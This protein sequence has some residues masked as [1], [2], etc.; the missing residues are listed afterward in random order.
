MGATGA[1]GATGVADATVIVASSGTVQDGTLS[2]DLVYTSA[3]LL[4]PVGT[5]L[6]FG[7][8][9]VQTTNNPDEVM[10][11]IWDSTHSTD[12]PNSNSAVVVTP[13]VGSPVAVS[14]S[15]LVTVSA[16]ET[17]QLKVFRNGSSTP[18]FG[19]NGTTLKSLKPQKLWAMKIK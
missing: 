15:V 12:I 7:Q 6:V 1:T 14:T 3:D 19:N 9:S 10:L 4:L 13:A 8:A 17:L 16:A 11:G 2:T 18:H 5:W